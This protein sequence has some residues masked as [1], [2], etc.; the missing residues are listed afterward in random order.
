MAKINLQ[1]TEMDNSSYQLSN[2]N[3]CPS[4]KESETISQSNSTKV[5]TASTKD[6]NET[7]SAQ[8]ESNIAY[9]GKTTD[10]KKKL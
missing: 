2:D 1:T 4:R 10:K 6:Q 3:L 8:T 5:A 7:R 9:I